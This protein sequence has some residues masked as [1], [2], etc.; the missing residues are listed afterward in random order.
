MTTMLGA[1][2]QF[3]RAHR[4]VVVFIFSTILTLAIAG[5]LIVRAF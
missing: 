2:T 1:L 5:P 4:T 3:A